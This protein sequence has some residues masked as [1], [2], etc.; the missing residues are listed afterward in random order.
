MFPLIF[1]C[2]GLVLLPHSQSGLCL[3]LVASLLCW[4]DFSS[5]SLPLQPIRYSCGLRG[6]SSYDSIAPTVPGKVCSATHVQAMSAGTSGH[7]FI[8]V[9]A[10]Y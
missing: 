6:S 1:S 3:D 2:P 5:H 4:I 9:K 10:V 8:V 7:C